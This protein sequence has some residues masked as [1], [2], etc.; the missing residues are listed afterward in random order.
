MNKG[1][2]L[3]LLLLGVGLALRLVKLGEASYTIDEINVVR[4]AVGQPSVDAIYKTE[5]ERFTWYHR[6]PFLMAVIHVWLKNFAEVAQGAFPTETDARLPFALFGTLT[7]PLFFLLGRAAGGVRTGWWLFGLATFNIFHLFYSREAYDYV[8]VMGFTAAALWAGVRLLRDCEQRVTFNWRVALAGG[9]ASWGLLQSHLAGLLFLGPWNA[10]LALALF[11]RARRTG[12]WPVVFGWLMVFGL[13]YLMFMPF[14]IR[15]FNFVTTESPVANRVSMAIVPALLGRMGWGEQLY[16]LIPFVACVIGG[17]IAAARGGGAQPGRWLLVQGALFLLVQTYAL[18]VGRFE[19]RYYAPIAPLLLL[20]AAWGLS[21][22][23]DRVRAPGVAR[24]FPVTAAVVVLALTAPSLRAVVDLQCRGGYNY[25]SLARWL[26]ENLPENGIYSY[27]N[28]YDGRGVPTV[29]PTPG[30]HMAYPVPWSS[31]EDYK[32]YQVRDRLAQFFQRFPHAV[33]VETA[34]IDLFAPTKITCPPIDRAQLF[35]HQTLITDPA[36]KAMVRWKTL[37]LG[38][39][40]P[41]SAHLDEMLVCHNRVE[42]LPE[43]ARKRGRALYHLFGKEWRFYKDQ[44]N[45]SDWLIT[46]QGGTFQVGSL[47]SNAVPVEIKLAAFAH[48][49]GCLLNVHSAQAG[50]ILTNFPVPSQPVE[51]PLPVQQLSSGRTE[52]F[53]EVL[54]PSGGGPAPSLLLHSVSLTPR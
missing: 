20:L 10:L 53:V 12:G 15:V 49:G 27:W 39:A 21:W 32:K 1:L 43:L 6:L 45:M 44:R 48:P 14:V 33:Y 7:L 19:V 18:R 29:Y 38:E 22:W 41:E 5:L 36:Y 2:W 16:A 26:N 52:F 51:I 23:Q 3:G 8:L 24:W 54:P 50:Q 17:G 35:A 11:L 37:P 28:V 42:D 34:P 40:Q 9:V 47:A 4:D 25:K 30:R 13:P 31:A 46:E